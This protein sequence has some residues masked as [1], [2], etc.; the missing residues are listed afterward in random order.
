MGGDVSLCGQQQLN[1]VWRTH[2]PTNANARPLPPRPALRRTTGPA[3]DKAT[4]RRRPGSTP[5]HRRIRRS[6]EQ[7]LR[8]AAQADRTRARA[9][10]PAGAPT[11]RGTTGPNCGLRP[12]AWPGRARRPQLWLTPAGLSTWHPGPGGG[13]A[14]A[15]ASQKCGPRR[16][17]TR[18][19]QKCGLAGRYAALGSATRA[20]PRRARSLGARPAELA[21]HAAMPPRMCPSMAPKCSARKSRVMLKSR[22]IFVPSNDHYSGENYSGFPSNDHYSGHYSGK[23]TRDSR[24]MTITRD[25]TRDNPE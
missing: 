8:I 1:K 9:T 2:R 12:P 6:T 20:R 25:I 5:S 13:G 16:P 10:T 17:G 7:R 23:I 14:A 18:A 3:Q 15:P 19:S 22:V 21:R 11:A 4:A 24:V